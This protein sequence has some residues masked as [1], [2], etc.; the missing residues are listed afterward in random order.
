M[1]KQCYFLQIQIDPIEWGGKHMVNIALLVRL[2][3]KPGK[4]AYVE[5]LIH[6]GLSIV[7]KRNQELQP[8]LESRWGRRHWHLRR[9]SRRVRSP[10]AFV[11]SSCC[12]SKGESLWAFLRGT[13]NKVDDIISS[14]LHQQITREDFMITL[15]NAGSVINFYYSTDYSIIF[16]HINT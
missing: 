13:R 4:E 15:R 7:S 12:S 9:L 5:R 6:Y 16:T 8:S 10:G 14:K 1:N 2:Q 3:V 11:R